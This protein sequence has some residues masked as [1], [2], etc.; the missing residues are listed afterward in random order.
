MTS[1]APIATGR[2][3][4]ADTDALPAAGH[5]A[6]EIGA[7]DQGEPRAERDGGDDVGPGHDPGVQH[8]LG[9]GADFPRDRMTRPEDLAVLAEMLLLLPGTAVVAELLVNCRFENI[10]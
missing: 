8:D 2:S 7:P 3:A 1:S 10:V 6:V 5:Q 4:S 9:V